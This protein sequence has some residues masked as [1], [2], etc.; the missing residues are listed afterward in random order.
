MEKQMIA[1]TVKRSV[2]LAAGRA[3]YG[4]SATDIQPMLAMLNQQERA[5][6]GDLIQ[7]NGCC[8]R[9]EAIGYSPLEVATIDPTPECLVEAFRARVVALDEAAVRQEEKNAQEK[10]AY[11]AKHALRVQ[12]AIAWLAEHPVAQCASSYFTSEIGYPIDILDHCQSHEY[13]AACLRDARELLAKQQAERE[14]RDREVEEKRIEKL[15]MWAKLNP[16]A[17]GV[18]VLTANVVRAAKE[19]RA[20]ESAV[21]AQ[22]ADKMLRY[23]DWILRYKIQITARAYEGALGQ[24]EERQDVPSERAYALLDVLRSNQLFIAA[25]SGM[26]SMQCVE[27]TIV[28][29]DTTPESK[30]FTWA[31]FVRLRF[32]SDL[33]RPISV[34]VLTENATEAEGEQED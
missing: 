6:L 1:Y 23:T 32:T 14:K 4:V 31:T 26:S 3:E 13:V 10:K 2:A 12:Q 16:A 11:E 17:D 7:P 21:Y 5:R 28:R 33:I 19:G 27:A 24:A 34:F 20:L 18:A 29:A 9:P 22:V 30:S 8:K 15:Q 25:S